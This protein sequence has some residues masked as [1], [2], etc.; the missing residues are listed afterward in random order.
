MFPPL[1]H[2]IRPAK[3]LRRRTSLASQQKI[4]SKYSTSTGFS[5]SYGSGPLQWARIS[6]LPTFVMSFSS[7]SSRQLPTTVPE[8][9][10]NRRLAKLCGQGIRNSWGPQSCALRQP[11]EAK[12]EWKELVSWPT[13]CG[14]G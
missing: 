9:Y 11:R 6:V 4:A 2:L 1:V 7:Y 10:Q 8:Y 5:R 13:G 14:G 12:I 3:L